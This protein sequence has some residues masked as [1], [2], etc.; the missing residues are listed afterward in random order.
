MQRTSLPTSSHQTQ[1]SSRATI[2]RGHETPNNSAFDTSADYHAGPSSSSYVATQSNYEGYNSDRSTR[3]L[4]FAKQFLDRIIDTNHI[5]S[6]RLRIGEGMPKT[7]HPLAKTQGIAHPHQ[8]THG[9]VLHHGETEP[10]VTLNLTAATEADQIQAPKKPLLSKNIHARCS[11]LKVGHRNIRTHRRKHR[12]PR[13][14]DGAPEDKDT[15]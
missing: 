1:T 15:A 8:T 3:T 14:I 4:L 6:P 9:S 13:P 5:R 12:K 7:N 10:A 2:T 11:P